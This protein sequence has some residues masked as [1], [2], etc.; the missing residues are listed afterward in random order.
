LKGSSGSSS[1]GVGKTLNGLVE[2]FLADDFAGV[3][4]GV[5]AVAAAVVLLFLGD[6]LA[7]SS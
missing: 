6:D 7:A 2:L 5:A 1:E 4:A 3:L